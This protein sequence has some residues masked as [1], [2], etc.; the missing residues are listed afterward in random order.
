MNTTD[1]KN[2]RFIA[3]DIDGTLLNS[4]NQLSSRF[5]PIFH[6]LRAAG[7]LVAV[8]SGRQFY[9]LYNQFQPIQHDLLFIAENG[10]YIF[11][12]GEE[13]LVKTLNPEIVKQLIDHAQGIPETYLI[14]CGK[15]G[16]YIQSTD[17]RFLEELNKYYA[18]YSIVTDLHEMAGEDILKVTLCDLINSETNSYPVFKEWEDRTK[19]KVSGKIWLDISHPDG[20]KG[21]AIAFVQQRYG[22]TP[23][24][25]MVFGDYLNDVEMI[26]QAY[27]SFAMEN[28]HPQIK[29][30]ARFRAKSNDDEGVVEVL[31]SL[32]EA[33]VKV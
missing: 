29:E 32:L 22:I 18:K 3:T 31:A 11:D 13:L 16:A 10:N 24:E 25:T 9:N 21:K 28:A 33:L 4:N 1:F 2:I 6:Q 20:D 19:V 30:L 5:Y 23:E 15:N 27:F 12:K 8:A 26:Q 14:L 7:I 17:E